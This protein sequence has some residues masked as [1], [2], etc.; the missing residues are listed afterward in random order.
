MSA[1]PVE[2]K[3][4]TLNSIKQNPIWQNVAVPSS[5]FIIPQRMVMIFF[6]QDFTF[7]QKGNDLIQQ[8]NVQLSFLQQL[9]VL[10]ERR[11]QK[12]LIHYQ[13]LLS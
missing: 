13:T 6:G 8:R 1:C 12:K 2:D 4:I 11:C 7:L 5:L 10:L 9:I 3:R